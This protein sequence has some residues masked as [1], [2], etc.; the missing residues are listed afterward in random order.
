M[1]NT[2]MLYEEQRGTL[3]EL[4]S[5]RHALGVGVFNWGR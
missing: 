5:A 1:R 4:R 3:S 2:P